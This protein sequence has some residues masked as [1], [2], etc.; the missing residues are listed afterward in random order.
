MSRRCEYGLR[1]LVDLGL[2]REAGEDRLRVGEIARRERI[3][4]KFLE[5]ILLQ[6]RRAGFVRSRRGREGGYSL[7]RAA[8]AIR[9]GAVVRLLDGPLA[10]LSCVSRT[11]YAPCTCPDERSCGLRSVM[12][13]ARNALSAVLDGYTLADA[14]AAE[15]RGRR[16]APRRSPR[17]KR[18]A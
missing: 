4:G 14:V 1:A 15:G 11:A 2:A 6:L 7:A 10:P 16:R 18:R 9:V 5:Q 3:P 12:G 8:R 17:R 13:R